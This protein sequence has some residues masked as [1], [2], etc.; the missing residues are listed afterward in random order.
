MRGRLPKTGSYTG[1]GSNGVSV[2]LGFKPKYVKIINYTDADVV[3]EWIDGM[4]DASALLTIDSGA[5]TSD[6]SKI[7]TAGITPTSLGFEIGTNAS[8]IE[9]NKVYYY[10]AH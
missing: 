8:L 3:A 9:T 2:N 10:I 1:D 6:L 4:P 5:G 7:T